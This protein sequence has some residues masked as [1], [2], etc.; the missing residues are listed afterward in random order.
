MAGG[1]VVEKAVVTC[2]QGALHVGNGAPSATASGAVALEI[3][4][5][6]CDRAR[7]RAGLDGTAIRGG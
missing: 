6:D 5:H 7:I 3:A 2:G 4:V 1:C